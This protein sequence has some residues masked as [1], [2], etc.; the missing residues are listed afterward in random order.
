MDLFKLLPEEIY[1]NNETMKLLQAILSMKTEET[2]KGLT[3]AVDQ[4]FIESASA[5]LARYEKI[6]GIPTDVEKSLRYRRE[7]IKAKISGAG[8]TT[9][10]LVQNI[11]ESYTNAAVELIEDF[12]AYT[13]TVRFVGTSGIP[14]N[15]ADI[16]ESIE[17]AMPAHLKVIYEY[18]FNTYGS[19]GTFTHAELA[20]YSHYKIRNG[21]L[22]N[23]TQELAAYQYEELA[24]L[25]HYDI[26]KGEL[27]NG[28]QHNQLWI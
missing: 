14:G 28:N 25:T 10:S 24:Q 23:R 27:P 7:R 4:C 26:S 1:E 21:H 6:L 11:A 13:V 8:T 19:V 18:I 20:A 2:E 5:V 16:K 3:T 22:K 12:A 17:E 9:A 15:I